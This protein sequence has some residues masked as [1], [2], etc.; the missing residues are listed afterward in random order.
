[1]LKNAAIVT[2]ML[3]GLLAQAA[4]GSEAA[5]EGAEHAKRPLLD[6]R[7]SEALWVVIIF[8]LM[9][10]VLYK[11]AWKNVLAGL[12]AR[13]ERIRT[14]IA[15]AEAARVK[16]EAAQKEYAAQ[17]SS[18][19]KTVNDMINAAKV[20]AERIAAGIRTRGEQE[21]QDARER[22]AR[23]IEA[24]KKQALS[25][26]Y[27]QT[28]QIATSVAEKILRRNLNADDQRD[29]VASSLEQLQGLNRTN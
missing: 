25:E 14:D 18:A 5:G 29:L 22:A 26:I 6:L 20:D 19:Q 15:E 10:I 7:V 9:M 2:T 3:I 12:K 28:A 21:A 24:A 13:E 11:T 17:L 23:E 8:T 4:L 27:D 16:A 1:M